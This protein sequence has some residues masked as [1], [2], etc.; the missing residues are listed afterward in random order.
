MA[1]LVHSINLLQT[2]VAATHS[3]GEN[4]Q[5][6]IFHYFIS[7]DFFYTSIIHQKNI[8]ARVIFL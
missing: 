5:L 4:N 3:C 8:F 6:R 1:C 7:I 2:A